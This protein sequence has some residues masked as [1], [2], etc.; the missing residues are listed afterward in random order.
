MVPKR[1]MPEAI[2]EQPLEGQ[3]RIFTSF[4]S[5][6]QLA[7]IEANLDLILHYYDEV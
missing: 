2:V 4:P 1:A 6:M 7:T 5:A 3:R